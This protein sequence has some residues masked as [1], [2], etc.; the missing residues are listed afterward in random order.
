MDKC[1]VSNKKI[2]Q[3]P[4]YLSCCIC[5]CVFHRK[6]L[7]LSNEEL[8]SVKVNRTKWFCEMCLVNS[9]PFNHIVD[10]TDFI[11]AHF[12]LS[13]TTAESF[14]YLSDKYS[15]HLK[16]MKM[17]TKCLVIMIQIS[18]SLTQYVSIKIHVI[19]TSRHHS[20]IC[21]LITT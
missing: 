19:I 9:L 21:L 5:C 20:M 3:H 10:D 1:P 8:V 18:M 17:T 13:S 6:C 12:E 11:A 16:L 4:R 7:P 2:L 14:K 15:T